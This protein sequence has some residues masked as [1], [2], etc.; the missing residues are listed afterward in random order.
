MLAE[1]VMRQVNSLAG[2]AS[3]WPSHAGRRTAWMR[4]LKK[5]ER[6]RNG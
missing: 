6:V 2:L 3:V 4:I 5:L 1:L